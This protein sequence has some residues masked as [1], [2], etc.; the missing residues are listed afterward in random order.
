M[1]CEA[2]ALD[3]KTRSK[4]EQK[5]FR[6]MSMG[7]VSK[8]HLLRKPRPVCQSYFRRECEIFQITSTKCPMP[9]IATYVASRGL[10]KGLKGF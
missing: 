8:H 6:K 10:L 7:F 2:K 4:N 5:W 9:K 1:D 3:K